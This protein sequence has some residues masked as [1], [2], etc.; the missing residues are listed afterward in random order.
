MVSMEPAGIEERCGRRAAREHSGGDQTV[1]L[2][3]LDDAADRL[4]PDLWAELRSFLVAAVYGA[5]HLRTGHRQEVGVRRLKPRQCQ[6]VL[7]GRANR[8]LVKLVRTR[9]SSAVVHYRPHGKRSPLLRHVLVNIVIG[10]ASQ[11]VIGG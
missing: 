1:L 10:K 11:G 6:G 7:T 5:I 9:A 8:L 2:G 4:R 3:A